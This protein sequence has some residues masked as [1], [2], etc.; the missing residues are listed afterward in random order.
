MQEVLS[1]KDIGGGVYEVWAYDFTTWKVGIPM[2]LVKIA[3]I[4]CHQEDP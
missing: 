3:T 1:V 4:T 2:Q